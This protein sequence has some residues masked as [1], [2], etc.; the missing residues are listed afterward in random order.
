MCSLHSDM[1]AL[2]EL[3]P[4]KL[5][6]VTP[7]PR[8]DRPLTHNL[9]E[10]NEEYESLLEGDHRMARKRKALREEGEDY[11]RASVDLGQTRF[12]YVPTNFLGPILRK[13]FREQQPV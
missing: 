9:V 13:R 8:E 11:L 7:P 12:Q 2:C 4:L 3:K 10:I 1:N 6:K 5:I